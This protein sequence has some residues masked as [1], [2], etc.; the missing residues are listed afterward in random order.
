MQK[1]VLI[2]RK[3]ITKYLGVKR[4]ALPLSIVSGKIICIYIHMYIQIYAHM[5][6]RE[7]MITEMGQNINHW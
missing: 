2:C 1:N 4:H 3:Y 6:E 7:T 5:F